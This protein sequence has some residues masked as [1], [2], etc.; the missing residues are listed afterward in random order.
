MMNLTAIPFW[1]WQS[2][3]AHPPVSG[4]PTLSLSDIKNA[5]FPE[6]LDICF[7]LSY[8]R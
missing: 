7:S 2:T 8:R 4:I 1:E 5:V 6:A 3:N